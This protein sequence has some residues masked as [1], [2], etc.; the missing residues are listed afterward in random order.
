MSAPVV[1]VGVTGSIAAYKA[2]DLV[3]KLVKRGFEVHVAMTHGAQEFVTPLTF[4]TL[5][6]NPVITSVFDDQRDWKPG[7]IDL[8]DRANLLLIAPATAN[9]LAEL[10]HGLAGNPIGEIALATLA[11]V[12]VAPAMNGKMWQHAATQDNVK[13]LRSRGVEFIGP[14]EGIL[15]CGYE[16]LGRLWNV[17][18]IVERVAH[19]IAQKK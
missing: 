16:G 11:P 14:E 9:I 2:A 17:D 10:A 8:A 4:Q 5:S 6:R 18:D 15:A 19:I 3:S 7:H 1:V 12:L 13:L